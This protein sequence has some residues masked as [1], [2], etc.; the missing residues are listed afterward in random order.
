[1]EQNLYNFYK[2]EFSTMQGI[3]NEVCTVNCIINRLGETQSINYYTD[4]T[5]YMFCGSNYMPT[6]HRAANITDT[7]KI[8][9]VVETKLICHFATFC[10]F[11]CFL[12]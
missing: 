4:Q 11:Y 10:D 1:M 12:F 9:R 7:P 2:L 3:W 5:R 8:F 6:T